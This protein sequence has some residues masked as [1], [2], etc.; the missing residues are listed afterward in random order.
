MGHKRK[1]RVFF[2]IPP[3]VQLLDFSG[4]AHLFYEAKEY[5]ADFE[6]HYLSLDKN[7]HQLSSAGISMGNLEYFGLHQLNK[8]DLLF[9]PGLES[10][11]LLSQQ[12]KEKHS[13]F[14]EW[15]KTQNQTGAKICSVCTGAYLMGM[16]GILDEKECT[17]HWKYIEDFKNR[18]SKA[19]VLSDRLIVKDGNIYSS[20]GVSSGID[21]A[22]YIIEE[23]L[24]PVFAS[25]IAKEVVIYSRRTPKDPQLSVYLRYRNHL[26]NRIH[27]V[28]DL[29][30]QNLENKVKVETLAEMVHM[31]RR[32]LT[33]LFK[34][35][36][37]TTIGDY[38]NQLRAE[39]AT[40]LL[41][42]GS[43]VSVA[44][45]ACGLKSSN[46]LRALLKKNPE[47]ISKN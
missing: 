3:E 27:V 6:T 14:F 40:E 12:F 17:T 5:G 45:Q 18:F 46:Q 28:Q 43:K 11:L 30:S 47:I 15:L 37:G 35:T 7:L 25:K 9:I 26:D 22:L 29:L 33:R 36:T 32:N 4:P 10:H 13:L 44:A 41:S 20:A 34:N 31:S 1:F 8:E 19:I 2:L 38:L 24:G 16:T 23:L 39:R 21:L 42:N